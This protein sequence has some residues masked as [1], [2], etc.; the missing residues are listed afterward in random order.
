MA[1]D[2]DVVGD[3]GAELRE[4][5]VEVFAQDAGATSASHVDVHVNAGCDEAVLGQMLEQVLV[6]LE[7]VARSV[8]VDNDHEREIRLRPADLT[9]CR[10]PG[11]VSWEPYAGP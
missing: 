2:A 6:S 11:S 1:H 3:L 10:R 9:G 5:D 7:A 4:Q 8:A